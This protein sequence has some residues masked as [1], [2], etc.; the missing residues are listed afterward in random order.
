MNPH[1][2]KYE[3]KI[4]DQLEEEEEKPH[5]MEPDIEQMSTVW[6]GRLDSAENQIGILKTV[7]KCTS[8]CG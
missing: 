6:C 1:N 3:T 4:K 7:Y 5:Q 2:T 8:I